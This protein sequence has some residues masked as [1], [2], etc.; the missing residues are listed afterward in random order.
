[1][2]GHEYYRTHYATLTA[3]KS[4][5]FDPKNHELSGAVTDGSMTLI[6]RTIIQKVISV[7]YN[8]ITMENILYLLPIVVMPLPVSIPITVGVISGH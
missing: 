1:M 3:S 7:V 5:M 8:M 6:P 4:N 2:V